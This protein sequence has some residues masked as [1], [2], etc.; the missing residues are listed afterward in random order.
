MRSWVL[1]VAVCVSAVF[2]LAGCPNADKKPKPDPSPSATPPP[3]ASTLTAAHG[4]DPAKGKALVE[5]QQCNRCHDGTGFDPAPQGKHCV[6]CHTDIM[7]AKFGSAESRV[8]W[9]PRVKDIQD[10]PSLEASSKRLGKKWIE[11]Y[12]LL[13]IDQRPALVQ[14]MPRLDLT[15][16]Q[17]RDI[18]AYL[19]AD[20]K[21]EPKPA[22]DVAKGRQILDTKGCGT[23]HKMTGVS[24]LAASPVTV[25][26][27]PKEYG[28]AMRTAPDLRFARDKMT[29]SRV[30]LWLT[31]P[32][33][34][35]PDSAMPKIPLSEAEVKDVVAYLYNAQIEAP[36]ITPP[37][38]RLPVLSRKVTFEE[39]DK[40]VFHRT[41]W[42]C[43][44]EPDYAIGDG[45]PGNSGGLGFKPRGLNLSDY[46]GIAAGFL[47]DKGE[48]ESVFAK[49]SAGVPRMVRALVARHAEEGGAPTG[50]VR[51][52]PLGYAPL[53]LEDIQ[54]VESWIAQGR[55]RS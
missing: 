31:D 6:H 51:G 41:C 49:D 46:A 34:V 25:A 9:Q 11:S 47:N 53:S 42:H 21:D 5:K 23:C 17:A 40:K 54:L 43:H 12:L 52:M 19:G 20:D 29:P 36:R 15:P 32:K 24:P 7:D 45:G 33:A 27:E 50:E 55:P 8:K 48:R 13:P 44:S 26:L 30:T 2:A 37:P 3:S 10:A 14:A 39:V 35:K 22:G 38:Q 28:R 4:G 16:E 1:P 18:A